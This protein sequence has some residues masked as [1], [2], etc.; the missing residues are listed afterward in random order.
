MKHKQNR[1]VATGVEMV[2]PCAWKDG[3]VPTTA[4]RPSITSVLLCLRYSSASLW[5]GGR[6][7][8]TG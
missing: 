6:L 4:S 8:S 2:I 5:R 3:K 7:Y 1:K